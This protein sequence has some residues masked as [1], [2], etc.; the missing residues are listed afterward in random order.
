M[1]R[2]DSGAASGWVVAPVIVQ[3]MTPIFHGATQKCRDAK[4]NSK[5]RRCI[6]RAMENPNYFQRLCYRVINNEV[7]AAYR[8]KTDWPV[9]QVTTE[10]AE[11]RTVSQSLAGAKEVSFELVSR[12]DIVRGDEAPDF[13]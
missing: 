6:E 9:G 2:A 12:C 7:C 3:L 11:V 1:Q 8:K 10:M 4:V 13:E 5:F